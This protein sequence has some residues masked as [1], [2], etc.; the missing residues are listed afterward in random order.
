MANFVAPAYVLTNL[1]PR[2]LNFRSAGLL[3]ATIARQ[4]PHGAATRYATI[5]YTQTL[6][7]SGRREAVSR[8]WQIRLLRYATS[9]WR[10]DD[11]TQAS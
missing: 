4:A 1:A 10:V 7:Q 5:A 6:T 9:D 2:T 8:I 3:S 11:V